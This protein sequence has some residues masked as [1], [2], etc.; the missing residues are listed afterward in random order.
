MFSRNFCNDWAG[1]INYG[2]VNSSLGKSSKYFRG[3]VHIPRVLS[4]RL[5]DKCSQVVL[6]LKMLDREHYLVLSMLVDPC[7]LV[8]MRY[9]QVEA[10]IINV[11]IMTV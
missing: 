6:A 5:S 11:L 4:D 3:L 10:K 8:S 7:F 1:T 2:E 9:L